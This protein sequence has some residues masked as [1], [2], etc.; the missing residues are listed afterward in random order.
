MIDLTRAR[1]AANFCPVQHSIYLRERR[2]QE[3]LIDHRNHGSALIPWNDGVDSEDDEIEKI[4]LGS[5]GRHIGQI[6]AAAMRAVRQ[7]EA[8]DPSLVPVSAV[9]RK[10]VP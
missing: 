10:S 4:T 2:D 6:M 9:P 3:K 7:Q 5:D 8:E 1:A